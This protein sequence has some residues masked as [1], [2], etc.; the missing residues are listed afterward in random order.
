MFDVEEEEE[1]RGQREE[2]LYHRP[3][4]YVQ[5]AA[6]HAAA[7]AGDAVEAIFADVDAAAGVEDEE[8]ER[9]AFGQRRTQG[10]AGD[11]HGREAEVAENQDVVEHHV[12]QHHHHRVQGQGAGLYRAQEE[13]SE[14]DGAKGEEGAEHAPVQIVFGSPADGG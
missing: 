5:H 7:E 9:H 10:G 11:A 8:Q 13:G 1:P 3:Q 12:A 4:R 2:V 14:D 6:Q